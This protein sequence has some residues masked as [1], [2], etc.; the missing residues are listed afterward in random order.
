MRLPRSITTFLIA[1]CSIVLLMGSITR[2]DYL[3]ANGALEVSLV[4]I[5][6][7]PE[8]YDGRQVRL[9]GYFVNE[10]EGRALYLTRDDAR[11]GNIENSVWI[12]EPSPMAK[13][14]SIATVRKHF[15][16]V[17]GTFKNHPNGGGGHMGLWSGSL[18]NITFLHWAK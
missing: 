4:K 1:V 7:N 2:A 6:A 9:T 16:R 17:D 13:A 3:L 12:D 18:T 5:I 8:R 10:F 14:G 11:I 15:V